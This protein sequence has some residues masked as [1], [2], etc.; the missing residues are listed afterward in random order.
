MLGA[1]AWH[2]RSDAA[3][4]LVVAVGIADNLLGIR[5]LI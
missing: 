3:S 2:A 4:S 5:F 1:N